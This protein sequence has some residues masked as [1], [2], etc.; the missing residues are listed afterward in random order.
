MT[1]NKLNLSY[2]TNETIRKST[3]IKRKKGFFK[4][5]HELSVLC[6]IQACAI[7]HS[8]FSSTPD[9]WPSNS[10]AKNV[11][12]RFEAI[13]ESEQ[14]KKMVNHEKF[15]EQCITKIKE[16]IIKKIKDNKERVMQETVYQFLREKGNMFQLTDKH[17]DDLCRFIDQQLKEL[18]YHRNQLLNQP[19]VEY[20]ESSAAA[21]AMTQPE[22]VAEEGFFSFLNPVAFN[23][24][25]NPI[26][27]PI[28]NLQPFDAFETNYPPAGS[29][30]PGYHHQMMSQVG[31]NYHLHQS[32]N[33]DLNPNQYHHQFEG[34]PNV[35]QDGNY[36]QTQN[37]NHQQEEWLVNQRMMNNPNQ[38]HFP[39][40][41][42][43]N[44]NNQL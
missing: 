7:I 11:V 39:M 34:Y 31:G 30:Q 14:E 35:A 33:L 5:I 4:K 23:T 42:D 36:N 27:S 18:H 17:R 44:N 10:E 12:E 26:I 2:I 6:G 43:N 21:N 40:M 19:H 20:G 41:D 32:L 15:L 25:P 28:Q 22:A 38:V 24:A 13:P 29:D 37:Q 3:F 9:V 16:K 8:P 1:R